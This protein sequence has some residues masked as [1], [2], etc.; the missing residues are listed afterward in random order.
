MLLRLGMISLMIGLGLTGCGY[1][2]SL[3]APSAVKA[4]AAS[5]TAKSGE[6]KAAPAAQPAAATKPF[7]LDGLI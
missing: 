4:A 7:I 5:D 2:G 3:E 1:K 6:A